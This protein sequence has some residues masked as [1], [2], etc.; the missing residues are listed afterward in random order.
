[1]KKVITLIVLAVLFALGLLLFLSGTEEDTMTYL[2]LV[3]A[4]GFVLL[5]I[6][7]ELF[8]G[9]TGLQDLREWLDNDAN[10]VE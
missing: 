4:S 8:K 1:M 7:V 2:L 9:L 5:Y 6:A 3:K 10:N